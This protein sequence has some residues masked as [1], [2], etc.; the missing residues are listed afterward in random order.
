M[1]KERFKIMAAVYTVLRRGNQVLFMRRA[2]A[3]YMDGKWGLP[4]GHLD[5][6][7]SLMTAAARETL[8]EA[9]VVVQLKEDDFVHTSHRRYVREDDGM[10][11]EYLDFYFVVDEWQGEPRI[12]EPDKCDGLEWFDVDN[13]PDTVIPQVAQ[14]V[15]DIKNGKSFRQ[16]G[17]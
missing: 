16:V 2:N 10:L 5:P 12:C 11:W 9:G 3:R 6:N 17:W 14:A 13:L 4:S 7:E 1:S 15:I 8:E